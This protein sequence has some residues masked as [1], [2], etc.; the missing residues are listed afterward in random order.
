VAQH[1]QLTHHNHRLRATRL[2]Q[3]PNFCAVLTPSKKYEHTS[4]LGNG[5]TL[6]TLGLEGVEKAKILAQVVGELMGGGSP[7]IT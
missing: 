7:V 1:C 6:H 5:A 4:S 2:L 3:E